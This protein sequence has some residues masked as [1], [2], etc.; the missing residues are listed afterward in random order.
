MGW[1]N[2]PD[3]G[4]EPQ[5]TDCPPKPGR[6]YPQV[7]FWVGSVSQKAGKRNSSQGLGVNVVDESNFF[8]KH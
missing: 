1:R 8:G 5:K 6:F 4:T 7:V 3:S 2:K